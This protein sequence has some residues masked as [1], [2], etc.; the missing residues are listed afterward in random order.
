[1]LGP[2]IL[3][4]AHT[5]VWGVAIPGIAVVGVSLEGELLTNGRAAMSIAKLS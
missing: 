5:G 3:V 2:A 1:V 4:C